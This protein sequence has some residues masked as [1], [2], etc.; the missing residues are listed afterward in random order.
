MRHFDTWYPQFGSRLNAIMLAK[1][2]E[3]LQYYQMSDPPY[4][5][6]GCQ[7]VTVQ[8]CLPDGAPEWMKE[9]I[10]IGVGCLA[11]AVET[12]ILANVP[13]WMKANMGA[14]GV[15]LGLL[16]TILSLAGPDVAETGLL[17]QRRPFIAL[18]IALGFP[19]VS[20]SRMFMSSDPAELLLSKKIYGI[21]NPNI[22]NIQSLGSRARHGIL[23]AEYLL[24]VT[25][26]A[27]V[28]HNSWQLGVQTVCSFSTETTYNP[29]VWALTAV[30]PAIMSA[31]S[32]ML[33]VTITEHQDGSPAFPIT[34]P[35]VAPIL[36]ARLQRM[37]QREFQLSGTPS[38]TTDIILRR[39]PAS[40]V[41]AIV[42]WLTSFSTILHLIYGTITC[43]TTVFISTQD[44]LGVVVRYLVS[45]LVC[46]IILNFEMSGMRA[47]VRGDAADGD[48][49][50]EAVIGVRPRAVQ[51]LRARTVP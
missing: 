47:V 42:A 50:G 40:Y 17:A 45:T 25:A 46:R 10:A 16:P 24:V 27:N 28:V 9:N 36:P 23:L 43:S 14:A 38:D 35:P 3:Q 29:L 31:L 4:S 18:L 13:E 32:T 33:H 8:T 12:C 39:K 15:L 22:I 19:A 41:A 7:A 44:A 26:I 21:N 49:H 51:V 5:C 1:C 34:P 2:S 20:P 48:G 11:E 30:L 6:R 37:L